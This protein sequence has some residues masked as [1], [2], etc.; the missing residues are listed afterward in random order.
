M[1]I[2][3]KFGNKNLKTIVLVGIAFILILSSVYFVF[4]D[5]NHNSSNASRDVSYNNQILPSSSNSTSQSTLYS[6]TFSET[7]LPSGYA[8]SVNLGGANKTS[9]TSSIVFKETNGVYYWNLRIFNST[10]SGN[11]YEGNITVNDSNVTQMIEFNRTQPQLYPVVFT[12]Q[13]LPSGMSWSVFLAGVSASSTSATIIFNETD[14]QYSYKIGNVTGYNSYPNGIVDVPNE[15]KVSVIFLPASST[16]YNITFKESGLP[17]GSIFSVNLGGT[18]V[19]STGSSI[20]FSETNGV[21]YWEVRLVPNNYYA[22]PGWGSVIVNGSN[23]TQE[24]LFN[25]SNPAIYDVT[26]T[27]IGLPAGT[28]WSVTLNGN[29]KSSSTDLISFEVPNGTYSYSIDGS[30]GYASFHR[31]GNVTVKGIGGNETAVFSAAC[32]SSVT[33]LTVIGILATISILFAVVLRFK[34]VK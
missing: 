27:E 30:S 2:P 17:T 34:R 28:S 8:F 19:T 16:L 33:I 15:V 12:E 22:N 18:N 29:T 6:I 23:V 25:S 32:I 1:A 20:S 4:G 11:P 31:E 26:F 3:R 7:G 14:G 21:Y 24:I 9:T 13:G 5:L 10:Y